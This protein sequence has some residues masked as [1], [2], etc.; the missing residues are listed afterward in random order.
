MDIH[1]MTYARFGGDELMEDLEFV[2]RPCHF[3]IHKVSIIRKIIKKKTG[4]TSTSK[5]KKNY[6]QKQKAKKAY[7]L[8]SAE[9]V[10]KYLNEKS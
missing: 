8:K 4:E 2:C 9:R 5:R 1:H 7:A 6:R 3:E 10:A